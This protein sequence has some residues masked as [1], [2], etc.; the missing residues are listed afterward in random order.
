MAG[1]DETEV[2]LIERRLAGT[3]PERG[4]PDLAVAPLRTVIA[5]MQA[6]VP[7]SGGLAR[8]EMELAEV[9]A[10]I[11]QADE[12][13]RLVEAAMA[14]WQRFAGDGEAPLAAV[15]FAITRAAIDLA[16]RKPEEA[17]ARLAVVKPV[18]MPERI[19]CDV[20]RARAYVMLGQSGEAVRAADAALQ[21]M[22]VLPE[23]WR[24]VSVQASALQA[25]G[26]A[27]L[28]AGNADEA[29][30]DL[31]A[32]LALRRAHDAPASL[33]HERAA[34]ALARAEDRSGHP[35]LARDLRA[36]AGRLDA[37]R[38]ATPPALVDA[39]VHG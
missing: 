39:R 24:P 2:A 11:G 33:W 25:R 27:R 34:L 30:G 35:D 9:L 21:A 26:E 10:E 5:N 16:G 13:Q 22:R 17:L 36:E 14:Q 31:S 1:L 7:N 29:I 12:A 28:A 6:T 23:G 20:L 32:A 4:R 8:S 15:A 38:R 18:G 3:L 19:R 37:A